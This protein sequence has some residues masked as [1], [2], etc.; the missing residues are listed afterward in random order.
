MGFGPKLF[1]FKS[2]ETEY[3]LRLLPFGGF[4]RME[5][6]E[7]ATQ[8]PRAFNNKPVLTRM[9]V[10]LAGP[11]MNFILA[12]ILIS[13]ISFFAGTAT[14]EILVM[15]ESPAALAGLK[16]GD[17]IYTI[18]G[19]KINIWEEIVEIIGQ[20][21]DKNIN[22]EVLRDGNILS[23]NIKTDVEQKTNR[24][25]IGIKAVVEKHSFAKSLKAGIYTTF[26]VVKTIL[27]GL[28]EMLKG[29]TKADVV[30]PVGIVHIV[31]EAAKIGFFNVL[32]L[33]AIISINLGLFNLFPIPALDGSKIVFLG[34][35]LIK[36]R[37]LD[38]E[39]E[40]FIHFIGFALLMVL[41]IF[42]L[43]KDLRKLN[44]LR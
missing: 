11:V 27:V 38:Q 17:I 15:P 39:K 6:E 31:G 44:L 24:G 4:V 5:G 7:E 43:L 3:S 22:V 34:I 12:I 33:A 14:T 25:M 37:A 21:P 32:Y 8:D 19:Q 13:I 29:Q 40:G 41:M 28:L 23:Y 16:N 10:I 30:G 1:E 18:E 20:K 35:E 9:G 2:Q 26:W 42:I 36:G